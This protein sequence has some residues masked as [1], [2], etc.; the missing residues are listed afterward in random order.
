VLRE[1]PY[2][3][4]TREVIGGAIEVH[5]SLGPGLLESAYRHCLAYELKERGL[6]VASE[7][8]IPLVYKSA[9]LQCGFRADIIVEDHV[10]L[11]LKAVDRLM[12][13]HEAQVLTYLK[14]CKIRVGLLINFNSTI[15]RH[16]IKRLAL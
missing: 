13:I 12:P 4:L 9:A 11:E 3:Q 7:M 16:G 6:A 15:L 5:R 10:L 1:Y 14:L 8:P 2:Q